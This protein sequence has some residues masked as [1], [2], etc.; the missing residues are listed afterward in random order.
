MLLVEVILAHKGWTM[1]E[2][3]GTYVD[4]PNRLVRVEVRDRNIFKTEDAERKLVEP[5]GIQGNID[6]LVGKFSEGRS[7]A[8]ASGTEDAVRVYA[9][10]ATR[11][12]AD[13]LAT[14]VAE[15]VKSYG[16]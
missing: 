12:E 3:L 6:Q 15:L 14:R 2:W 8:R 11:A 13:Q 9:E 4:L 5:K 7:F 16:A 1:K 10:A